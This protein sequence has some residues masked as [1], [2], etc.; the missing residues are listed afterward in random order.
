M[1]DNLALW[2]AVSTTD[3]ASTKQFSR[4]GGFSGTAISP[5]WL[6]R[7]ATEQWGPMGEKWGV[8]II[9]SGVLD[10]HPLLDAKGQVVGVAKIH[11]VQAEVF[12]PGG[13]VPCFGQTTLVGQNKHGFFTDEEAPKKSL[14]DALTKGLSWLGFAADVHM[15]LYDDVKY[16]AELKKQFS[17]N[18]KKDKSSGFVGSH[19]SDTNGNGEHEQP[20]PPDEPDPILQGWADQMYACKDLDELGR[21]W[22]GMTKDHRVILQDV[23]DDVKKL[24]SKQP[25][26]AA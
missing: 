13:S 2:N 18:G 15:G 8:R 7:R 17:A 25:Q 16:V 21:V 26:G 1:N 4:G 10:G 6:I 11:F 9:Q 23:K 24:L 20:A 14:T 19:S 5:T 22:Q 3:P 12:H